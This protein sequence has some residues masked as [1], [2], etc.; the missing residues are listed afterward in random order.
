MSQ[1]LIPP[2]SGP[3]TVGTST[4]NATLSDSGIAIAGSVTNAPLLL[5]AAGTGAIQTTSSG[6][7]RGLY[8]VDLQHYN[9]TVTA[10]ASGNYSAA[11]GRGT[12]ASGFYSSAFG[13]YSSASGFASAA[14]GESTASGFASAAFG[15][16]T[17]S[18]S[19]SFA[20]GRNS[21][22]GYP[23]SS[24][25]FSGTTVT[26]SGNVLNQFGV[27]DTVLYSASGISP[28]TTTVS[29]ASYA[30]PNTTLTLAATPT[31]GSNKIVSTTKGEYGEATG[32]QSAA[33]Q[34]GEQARSLGPFAHPGDSQVSTFVVRNVTT[35]TT[36]TNLFLDGSSKGIILPANQTAW[37]Y[38]VE[39]SAYDSTT[40]DSGMFKIE[41]GIKL[42]NS[43]TY[44]LV[45]TTS[46]VS[47]LDS[48]F[49][50]SATVTATSGFQVQVTGIST[51]TIR[52]TAKV[53]I[54][55]T[56]FGTP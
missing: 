27:G 41:G 50:G 5:Q 9:G 47:W 2:L 28:G 55:Q 43:G 39:V 30:S 1:L 12:T 8:A 29:A 34:Y 15:D 21:T 10:V 33:R 38:T 19:Y 6:N 52:W 42:N 3:V 53:D 23:A 49:T 20:S 26:I 48:G 40:N 22:T 25:T 17:A 7:A 4:Q 16:S 18:G 11:F 14:F 51:D 24:M 36:A 54:V 32:L 13:F 44:S 46:S 37:K 35:N 56:S 31:A 45:G